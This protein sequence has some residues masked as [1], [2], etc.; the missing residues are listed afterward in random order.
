MFDFSYFFSFLPLVFFFSC[1]VSL[2]LSCL[3]LLTS[4]FAFSKRRSSGCWPFSVCL[5][6]TYE[7][8]C[9]PW[10]M[11]FC[12]DSWFSISILLLQLPPPSLPKSSFW[13]CKHHLLNI[14]GD[15]LLHLEYNLN[16]NSSS[17]QEMWLVNCTFIE[18]GRCISNY[19]WWENID[20]K[21]L[22]SILT[23]FWKKSL[24]YTF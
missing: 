17:I 21:I 6:F 15:W 19:F 1:H 16:L 2:I 5:I 22:T 7:G 3:F 23:G 4:T 20:N 24:V 11:D 8:K 10:V 9:E 18:A 13:S 14:N 12:D